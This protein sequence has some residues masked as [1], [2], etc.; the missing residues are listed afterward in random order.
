MRVCILGQY[1]PHIGGVSSH[2]YLLSQEL[3]KRGDDVYVLT[4]PH[5]DAKDLGPVKVETAATP[6]IKGL[7]GLLFFGSAFFKLRSMVRRY[8]ID[9]IHAHFLLP[10]GLIAVYIGSWMNKKTAVTAHGS[11]LMIQAKNPLLKRFIQSVLK[12]TDYV[13]VV[14]NDL[15]DKVLNMGINPEKVYVTPNAIDTERFN[16]Q[17]TELPPG[18]KMSSDKPTLLFVGNLVYQKGVEYLLEAKKLMKTDVELLIVGDGPLR[19]K[20]EKKVR[21]EKISDVV[22]TGARRDVEKIMPSAS[23][24]VLPSISEGFPITIL[25]AMASGLPVVATNV[26]GIKEVMN[27]KVGSMVKPAEPLELARALDE[28]LQN[29]ELRQK[30]ALAAQEHSHKYSTLKVPY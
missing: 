1:P 14:N 15:K 7:R 11:D 8:Q 9:L 30:K 21:D 12:K 16:P 6:N 17:K 25:E 4:Y 23:V 29:E 20:L 13:M 18:I 2:T 24:F 28:I 3:V 19:S 10:P 22:F 5:K 26:G 27:E